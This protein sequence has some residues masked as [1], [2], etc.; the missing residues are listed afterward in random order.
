MKYGVAKKSPLSKVFGV[1]VHPITIFSISQLMWIALTILWVIWYVERLDDISQ[2]EK[3]S[4]KMIDHDAP[5]SVLV[6][7]LTLLISMLIGS[8]WLFVVG[9]KRAYDFQQQQIF[10]SSVTHELRSPLA[11]LLLMIETLKNRDPPSDVRQQLLENGEKDC[12]RLL[13]MVNQ[14]L[15]SARLDRGIET[16]DEKIESVDLLSMIKQASAR[17]EIIEKRC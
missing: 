14:I 3:L 12:Q 6:S 2:L 15:L 11:S 7:G 16:L 1:I 8:I 17:S 10:V 4:S 13:R 5:L 9:Q